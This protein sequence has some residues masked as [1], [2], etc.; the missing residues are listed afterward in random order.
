[1]IQ[2]PTSVPRILS[3]F[4]YP[5]SGP[6]RDEARCER[7][8]K[9]YE[10]DFDSHL[11]AHLDRHGLSGERVERPGGGVSAVEAK[12][13]VE[14]E[15]FSGLEIQRRRAGIPDASADFPVSGHDGVAGRLDG[16]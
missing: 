3:L 9:S 4:S 6:R 10:E 5:P 14:I 12:R 1:M 16:P 8:G 7:N 15:L 11:A 2:L 13:Q